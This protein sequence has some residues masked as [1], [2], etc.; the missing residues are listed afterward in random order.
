MIEKVKNFNMLSVC[1]NIIH[2]SF[3]TVAEDFGLTIENCPN[4]TSFIK[5]DKLEKQFSDKTDMFLYEKN[6][7]YVGYFSLIK[8][9]TKAYELDNLAVLPEYRHMGI[10][11]EMVEYAE[12]YVALRNGDVICIGI[13][14]ENAVLREWYKELGFIHKGTKIFDHLPFTV[15]FMEMSLK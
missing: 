6:G 8:K 1:Q 4:H 7:A 14:E 15:G 2:K 5:T 13:I 9:S 11:R 3:A 12:N 10:G